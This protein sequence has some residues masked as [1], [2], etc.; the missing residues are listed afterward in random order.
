MSFKSHGNALPEGYRLL[1]YRIGRALGQGGFGITYEALDTNLEKTVAIKEYLPREFAVREGDSTVRPFTEDRKQMF[2][3]GLDRFL[4]EARTL[5][6]FDHP[7]I[8]RVHNVFE[9]NGTAYMVM[10]FEQGEAL[11][12]LF[13]F[14]RIESEADLQ[15]IAYPLLDGL[16]YIHEAGFIHRDIKP[17]NIYVRQDGSPVL[18]DFGSARFAIGGETKTL[19][20]LVT[21]GFAPYEQYNTETGKQGPWTDIY[22][23]GATLYTGLKGGC[24]PLD[25]IARGN[26]CIE[27]KVDPLIP[28]VDV[29]KGKYSES[30]LSAIDAALQFQSNDRPQTIHKWRSMFPDIKPTANRHRSITDE[31][32]TVIADINTE[33]R[34]EESSERKDPLSTNRLLNEASEIPS[35]PGA[36]KSKSHIRFAF[37]MIAGFLILA[38]L[39]FLSPLT[40]DEHS[41]KGASISILGPEDDALIVAPT[42]SYKWEFIPTTNIQFEVERQTEDGKIHQERLVRTSFNER[43]LTGIIRWRVRPVWKNDL[44]KEVEGVWSAFRTVHYYKNTLNKII[45]TATLHIGIAEEDGIYVR[46]EDGKLGGLEV[47]LLRKLFTNLIRAAGGDRNLR[48]DYT[49]AVWGDQFFGLLKNKEIDVLVSGISALR[50][51]EN[52]YSIAFSSPYINYTNGLL[53]HNGTTPFIGRS[54]GLSRVGVAKKTTNELVGRRLLV[55]A[56]KNV[57]QLY[58]GSNTYESMTRDLVLNKLDGVLLDEPYVIKFFNLLKSDGHDICFRLI[59]EDLLSP[60]HSENIG[61]AVRASDHELLVGINAFLKTNYTIVTKLKDRFLPK[62]RFRN[63]E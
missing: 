5:A 30:F 44:G 1:W 28:A 55:D 38:F 2:E 59:E 14:R 53:F 48:I 51:R 62:P 29:G 50:E 32:P 12:R 6:K 37:A 61:M 7:N 63:C 46:L 21:P 15:R 13:K 36:A 40:L 35:Y 9:D 20:S 47:E 41:M 17:P 18:L 49:Y 24:G 33:V 4:Q 54:L 39:M 23:M 45:E 57:L 43:Q 26:A 16:E 19:T 27:G 56:D 31:T 42:L 22:G 25:A 60:V 52:R 58:S 8:V 3:W 34:A 10:Q 11:D